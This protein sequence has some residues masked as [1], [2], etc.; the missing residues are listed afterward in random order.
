MKNFVFITSDAI[1]HFTFYVS[2]LLFSH[3]LDCTN[4]YHCLMSSNVTDLLNFISIFDGKIPIS[5]KRVNKHDFNVY[6]LLFLT[7]VSFFKS[8]HIVGV[9]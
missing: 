5:M 2:Y 1:D 9:T 7:Q 8:I 4:D 6:L 3:E